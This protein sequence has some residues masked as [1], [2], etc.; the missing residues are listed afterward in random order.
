MRVP[1]ESALF[2]SF[3]RMR[4]PTFESSQKISSHAKTVKKTAIASSPRPAASPTTTTMIA[5][6]VTFGLS[7]T[8]LKRI[9]PPI[10]KMTNAIVGS[11][12]TSSETIAP[13]IASTIKVLRCSKSSTGSPLPDRRG[14]HAIANPQS[15]ETAR[16]SSSDPTNHGF[17]KC[18]IELCTL[19]AFMGCFDCC[20]KSGIIE[21]PFSNI[22][23]NGVGQKFINCIVRLLSP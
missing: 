12:R 16:P 20:S 14:C 9:N 2:P 15:A 23:N 6:P 11:T 1:L 10:P 21:V 17:V 7:S 22:A 18:S 13:T 4:N 5:F 19:F 3:K 8:V